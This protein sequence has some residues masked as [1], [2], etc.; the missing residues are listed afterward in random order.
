MCK[1]ITLEKNASGDAVPLNA[2][3][4]QFENF[5]AT[6]VA[7]TGGAPRYIDISFTA[8]GKA[9]GPIRYYLHF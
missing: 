3:R 5:S 9:V 2:Q 7:P 4:V 1:V 8:N 6:Q